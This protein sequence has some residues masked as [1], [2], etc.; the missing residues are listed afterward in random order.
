[1]NRF[2]FYRSLP[3]VFMLL[4]L[5]VAVGAHAEQNLKFTPPSENSLPTDKFGELVLEGKDLFIHTDKLRGKY[6]N[7]GLKCVNCHMDAG[8][9]ADASPL[10]AAYTMYPAFRKKTGR[11][12][13]FEERLQG[14]FKYSMNG[15]APPAGSR[16]LV[17]LTAYSYWLASKAPVGVSLPGRGYPKV[18]KPAQTPSIERGAKVYSAQCSLCH[19]ENGAG[20]QVDAAYV[21]PPLWG[22]DSFNWGAGMHRVDTAA[23]FIKGNM[24]LGKPNSLS[25]QDAWD[26]ASFINSRERPQDP[27]FSGD[28]AATKKTYHDENCHYGDSVERRV[29]GAQKNN[30]DN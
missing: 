18:E 24:P 10:W 9:H 6:V 5:I 13:T 29:L 1:M 25:D 27:R 30:P 16:E 11:V 2:R 17:A 15:T 22:K 4:S 12:D 21:F 20:T 19:G 8:R 7:N 14:C 28:V 23:G 3:N 26:V